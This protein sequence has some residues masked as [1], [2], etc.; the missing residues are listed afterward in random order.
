MMYTFQEIPLRKTESAIPP[1][2]ISFIIGI[3]VLFVGI[4]AFETFGRVV[5]MIISLIFFL[6]VPMVFIRPRQLREISEIEKENESIINM[7]DEALTLMKQES[8][9]Q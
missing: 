1:L 8:G 6:V 7:R 3:A 2:M 5:S 9:Q 4:A